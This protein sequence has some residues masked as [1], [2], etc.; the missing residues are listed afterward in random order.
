MKLRFFRWWRRFLC[1]R[2]GHDMRGIGYLGVGCI[3]CGL[4]EPGWASNQDK[5]HQ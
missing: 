4:Q 1:R 5:S 3:R 2:Y